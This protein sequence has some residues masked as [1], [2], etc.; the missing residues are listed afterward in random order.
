MGGLFI[1]AV[2]GGFVAKEDIAAQVI[3]QRGALAGFG[4]HQQAGGQAVTHGAIQDAG[5]GFGEQGRT[6]FVRFHP[7]KIVGGHAIHHGQA[8]F[9]T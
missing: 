6:S 7:D 1:E 2:D 9:P 5:V 3:G 4:Y 8:I